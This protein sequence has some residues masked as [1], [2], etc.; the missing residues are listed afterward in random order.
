MLPNWRVN[1]K[2]FIGIKGD[3][4]KEVATEQ[5]IEIND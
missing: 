2:F 5:R 1:T 4:I 3:L